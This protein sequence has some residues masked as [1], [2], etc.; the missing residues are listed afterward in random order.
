MRLGLLTLLST[1]LLLSLTGCEENS[2]GTN[3]ELQSLGVLNINGTEYSITRGNFDSMQPS[4]HFV[5]LSTTGI[6]VSDRMMSGFGELIIIRVMS[7]ESRELLPGTYTWSTDVAESNAF[8]ITVYTGFNCGTHS[9]DHMYVPTV[10]SMTVSKDG[11]LYTLSVTLTCN[12]LAD[13]GELWEQNLPVTIT[14]EGALPLV[15]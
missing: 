2:S 8:S 13:S 14:Y 12:K 4:C 7:N 11:I 15:Q 1:L 3:D 6:D 9:C 5:R 10:G